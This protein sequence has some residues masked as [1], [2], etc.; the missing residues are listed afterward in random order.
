MANRRRDLRE[1]QL[2]LFEPSAEWQPPDLA[3]LPSWK[4]AKRIGIDCETRDP[5]IRVLGPGPRRGGKMIGFSFAIED[6]PKHYLPWGHEGGGNLP[7]ENCKAYLREQFKHYD[8][9][10]VGAN[11]SYELDYMWTEGIDSPNN[12]KVKRYYDVQIA[13]PLI[14]ELHMKYSL[15][16]ILQRWGFA[17]K[18]ES[19]LKEWADAYGLDPKQD[20]WRAHSKFVGEYAEDDAAEPLKLLRKLEHKLDEDQLLRVWDIESRLLPALTRMRFRGVRVDERRLDLVE[21]W[22]IREEQKACDLIKHETGIALR[23]GTLNNADVLRPALEAAG[24]SHA[25]TAAGLEALK[26]PVA[27]AMVRARKF[28]K[29]RTTFVESVRK[30]MTQGRI[31]CSFHQMRKTDEGDDENKG[32]AYGRLS[33]T[34]PNMQ[35][36]PGA[37]DEEVGPVWRSVYRPDTDLWASNDYSQQEPKWSFHIS[38]LM[39]YPGAKEICDALRA[40]P[41]LDT[42]QPLADA[43][44]IK[45]KPAKIVWLARAYG[46]GGGQLC[47]NLGLPTRYMT[48]DRDNKCKV[49][50]ESQRGQE[51]I[52]AGNFSWRDAGEEAQAT[53]IDPFDNRMPFLKMAA[54]AA[55]RRAATKGFVRTVLG[56]RLHFEKDMKGEYQW[57]YKAFNREVQGCAADQTKAS[58]VAMDEAGFPLQLQVHDEINWSVAS[59]EEAE[60]GARIMRETIPLRIPVKVDVELGDSWGDSMKRGA[61]TLGE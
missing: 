43:C 21:E 54:K 7:E 34:D 37:K 3:S 16:A 29:L 53:I 46:Q 33:C 19:K 6:G 52:A 26:H 22:S 56:R 13:E 55:T 18:T 48:W 2:I 28:W 23:V 47:D 45:R 42:Y 15:D 44:G 1:T 30:Y 8:G 12:R 57:T 14:W 51:L 59:R 32:V 25:T 35:Q 38:E 39:E 24:L 11:L 41:D 36:Q 61:W 17:G 60:E 10:I 5:L 49:P 31:H 4:G 27:S 20:M 40:N 58:V 9:E 50:V